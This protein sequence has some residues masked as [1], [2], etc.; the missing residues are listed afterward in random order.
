VRELLVR[1]DLQTVSGAKRS[2]TRTGAIGR[3]CEQACP[4][5]GARTSSSQR[6]ANCFRRK[7]ESDA[8]RGNRA[9]L[10]AGMPARR[11]ANFQFAETRKL[12]LAQKRVGRGPAVGRCC[13]RHARAPVREL[14]VRRD[15]QTVLAQKTS[16]TSDVWSGWS[17]RARR[18]H[19]HP[20]RR[21]RNLSPASLRRT[22]AATMT[23]PGRAGPQPRQR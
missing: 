9:L 2:R 11:R 4:R 12:F 20:H 3:C 15:P 7:N 1:R 8:D 22:A 21:S 16:Q 5:P 17:R 13:G 23:P 18:N 6:P 19:L 14:P 10:R